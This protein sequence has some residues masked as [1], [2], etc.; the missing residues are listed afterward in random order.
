MFEGIVKRTCFW[1]GKK[2]K[3]CCCWCCDWGWIWFMG[4]CCNGWGAAC[5]MVCDFGSLFIVTNTG[6]SDL[7]SLLF[8]FLFGFDWNWEDFHLKFVN[9]ISFIRLT[10]DWIF[11]AP[12]FVSD[13]CDSLHLFDWV[14]DVNCFEQT[15]HWNTFPAPSSFA[16]GWIL[17]N[18][19]FSISFSVSRSI[20]DRSPPVLTQIV[21]PGKQFMAQITREH[22]F[23]AK[24]MEI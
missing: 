1:S 8:S 17:E 20:L 21:F 11:P 23:P 7:L 10:L 24:I 18:G 2:V 16:S 12:F 3:I 15:G 14:L 4:C 13:W 6:S 19:K 22:L 9:L 5:W